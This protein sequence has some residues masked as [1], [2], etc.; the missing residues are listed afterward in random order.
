MKSRRCCFLPYL[1]T[2]DLALFRLKLFQ[3]GIL[4][5]QPPQE[6]YPLI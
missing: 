6:L 2:V 3:H 1:D 5:F 4:E